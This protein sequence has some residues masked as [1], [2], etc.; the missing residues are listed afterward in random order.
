[1]SLSSPI[2]IRWPWHRLSRRVAQ[3]AGWRQIRYALQLLLDRRW[4][5]YLI[6]DSFFLF[7][8]LLEAI[9]DMGGSDWLARLYPRIVV[10]P[11][12]VLGLPAMSSVVSLERRAG[13]LD[14][15]LAV[16]ST[17]RYFLRR[18]LPISGFMV[19][20]SWLV[21]LL[22]ADGW[23]VVRALFQS[24]VLAALLTSIVL[25][26][27]VRLKTSGAV[28]VA[29]AI[30]AGLLTPWIFFSPQ[31]QPVL[32]LPQEFWGVPVA[33]LVWSWKAAMQALA[34]LIFFL[35]ARQRLRRPEAM[36]A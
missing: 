34:A 4:T 2:T 24:T 32:G 9:G 29:S 1:M 20:Q 6:G 22:A 27:A 26:W 11:M 31:M 15:A 36:L 23:G 30:T 19:L 5:L 25:F 21:L 12:L 8:G 33:I 18:V 7:A 3:S 10:M 13:S 16:P 28:L 17:E 14:L 35:Y